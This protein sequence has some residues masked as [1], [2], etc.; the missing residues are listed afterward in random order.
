MSPA[1]T[2]VPVDR[3]T[4]FLD[5]VKAGTRVLRLEEHVKFKISPQDWSKIRGEYSLYKDEGVW[6]YTYDAAKSILTL[7]GGPSAIH[8][9]MVN[10]IHESIPPRAQRPASVQIEHANETQKADGSMKTPDLSILELDR[11][12]NETLKWALEVGFSQPYKDLKEAARLILEGAASD[13]VQCVLVAITE[14]P[15][16]KCPLSKEE[17]REGWE[18]PKN[19][20]AAEFRGEAYG[21]RSYRGHQWVGEI[22]KIWWEVWKFDTCTGKARK[23]GKRRII[24]PKSSSTPVTIRLDEIYSIPR[25]DGLLRLDWDLFRDMLQIAV[26]RQAKKRYTQWYKSDKSDDLKD[27]NYVEEDNEDV[28]DDDEDQ[29]DEDQ[30]KAEEEADGEGEEEEEVQQHGKKKRRLR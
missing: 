6:R 16:Y 2:S 10:F 15:K 30:E 25:E 22:S 9:V 3:L 19:V 28:E 14:D 21:P 13:T 27:K 17:G 26:G 20:D 12:G 11:S 24:H 5:R 1:A 23:I 7:Q 18:D 4:T 29:E 8:E